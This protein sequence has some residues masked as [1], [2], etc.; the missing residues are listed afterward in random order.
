M[1]KVRVKEEVLVPTAVMLVLVLASLITVVEVGPPRIGIRV[2]A[3]PLNTGR[4]GTSRVLEILKE[5]FSNVRVV[6]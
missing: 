2:G 6:L 5:E 1:K 4:F 3:S